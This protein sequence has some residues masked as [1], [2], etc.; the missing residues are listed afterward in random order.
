MRTNAL[1]IAM[2]TCKARL[3]ESSLLELKKEVRATS[4]SAENKL[5]EER[6]KSE[7]LNKSLASAETENNNLRQKLSEQKGELEQLNQKFTK[8]FEN[9]A[10][11][12]FLSFLKESLK[13]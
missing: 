9:L 5:Q 11:R 4:E 1:I 8:E 10:N 12:N 2:F 6:K 7:S 13:S 3:L